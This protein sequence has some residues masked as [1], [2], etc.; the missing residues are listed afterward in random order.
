MK[1]ERFQNRG[2]LD[3]KGYKNQQKI[4]VFRIRGCEHFLKLFLD[5]LWR[6]SA[7][8]W[9]RKTLKLIGKV[10]E[11]QGFRFF[12]LERFFDRFLLEFCSVLAPKTLQ[13]PLPEALEKRDDFQT[14]FLMFF[15]H[16]LPPFWHQKASRSF[17]E[18]CFFFNAFS[19]FL[20]H[21]VPVLIFLVPGGAP[22]P[23]LVVFWMI[24]GRLGSIFGR[25]SVILRIRG[26]FP[27]A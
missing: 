16:F 14:P 24:W 2:F 17:D 6:V 23:M 3:Q 20:G 13:N 12:D 9:D 7:P 18:V 21:W 10:I 19:D 27:G 4:G 26:R 8:F 25:F 1:L 22:D 5:V 11:N 15:G